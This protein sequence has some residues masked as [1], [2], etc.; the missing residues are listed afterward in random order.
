M[1]LLWYDF[2]VFAVY[3]DSVGHNDPL[4][5]IELYPQEL[6]HKALPK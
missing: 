5:E 1:C 4:I 2:L 3:I 6:I